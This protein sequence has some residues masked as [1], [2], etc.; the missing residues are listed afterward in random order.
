[1]LMSSENLVLKS[2]NLSF[3]DKYFSIHIVATL[4]RLP[5]FVVNSLSLVSFAS[6]RTNIIFIQID[7]GREFIN[8]S[9]SSLWRALR[10][11]SGKKIINNL[12]TLI[13]LTR[14]LLGFFPLSSRIR[15]SWRMEMRREG[16]ERQKKSFSLKFTARI[17]SE[18]LIRS[19]NI[20]DVEAR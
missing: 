4:V 7:P 10:R 19:E 14:L 2:L 3:E 13:M 6:Q 9:A 1:M 8:C 5:S 16:M 11:K 12:W 18:V 17:K 20:F 15:D